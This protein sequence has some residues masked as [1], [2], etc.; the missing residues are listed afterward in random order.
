M[1]FLLAASA[2]LAIELALTPSFADEDPRRKQAEASFQEGLK[3]HDQ[4]REAEALEKF[5]EAYGVYP[6]PNALFQIARSEELLGRPAEAIRHYREALRS[7]LLHPK[8][9]ELG[10]QYI[11]ALEKRLARVELRGLPGMKVVVLG[12]EYTLPLEEPIDVDVTGPIVATGTLG[13]E[14]YEGQAI[15]TTAS[16]TRLEMAPKHVE[17]ARPAPSGALTM[18]EPPA[19]PR[20]SF[21]TARRTAGAVLGGAGA[22]SVIGGVLLLL[23]AEGESEDGRRATA[24]VSTCL[25]VDSPACREA[26]RAAEAERDLRTASVVSFIGGGLLLAAGA[27]LVLWPRASASASARGKKLVL[28][29]IES[30]PT[31]GPVLS[32]RGSMLNL[33]QAF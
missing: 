24:D 31:S 3:L 13:G 30:S 29:P 28:G 20:E 1:R 19:D 33:S 23:A 14:Q 2:V 22:V 6:S 32:L 5:R 25:G 7:P 8:N 15:A 17:T 9:V 18:V 10:R 16:L 26:W 12:K 27:A 4:G 21:W 11:S